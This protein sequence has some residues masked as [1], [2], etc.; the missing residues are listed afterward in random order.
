MTTDLLSLAP[1]DD[2]GRVRVV[3]ETPRGS[4][5][6]YDFDPK[7]GAIT[8]AKQLALGLRYPYDW[9]FVPG[10]QAADGDPVDAMVVHSFDTYPGVVLPC[11]LVGMVLIREREQGEDWISNHRLIAVP[12]WHGS[13]EGTGP[14][15]KL[16]IA[17][18]EQFFLNT[19]FFTAKEVRV[20]GWAGPREARALITKSRR[21]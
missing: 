20:K 8:A 14:L 7:T 2:D 12:A 16:L 9:G 17:E 15:S 13:T 18:L 11:R 21:R 19:S 1:F 6:K 3:V 4:A 5:L 10:T